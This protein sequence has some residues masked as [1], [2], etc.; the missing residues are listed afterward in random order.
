[1]FFQN[2]A[3]VVIYTHICTNAHVFSYICI[4]RNIYLEKC[5]YSHLYVHVNIYKLTKMSA[6]THAHT[7][8]KIAI[9]FI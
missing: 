4:Y 6:S 5:I 8:F 1:M 3:Y 2:A 7:Y 9:S